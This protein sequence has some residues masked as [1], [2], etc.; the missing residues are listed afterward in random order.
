MKNIIEIEGIKLDKI[1]KHPKL[2]ILGAVGYRSCL[3]F[4]TSLN[5]L[6][7][8]IDSNKQ[9]RFYSSIFIDIPYELQLENKRS[10]HLDANKR[11]KNKKNKFFCLGGESGVIKILNIESCEFESYLK[12]HT[13]KIYDMKSYKHFLITCSGDSSIRFWNL[14]NYTCVGV[15]G[16]FG[17]HKDQVLSID[18]NED[19]NLL[20]STGTDLTIRQWKIDFKKLGLEKKFIVNES[21][22]T[23]DSINNGSIVKVGYYGD[24]I[25]SLSNKTIT[26]VYNN[27][28]LKS[29]SEELMNE[30]EFIINCNLRNDD[31]L[32]NDNELINN[33]E[34]MNSNELMNDNETINNVEL[35]NSNE[36]INN[37]QLMGLQ[38]EKKNILLKLVENNDQI[39]NLT[40][41]L[42]INDAIFIGL[43]KFNDFCIN[44]RIIKKHLLIGMS[45]NG[46]IYLY[47]LKLLTKECNLYI[48]ES[49][50]KNVE[51]FEIVDDYM[52]ITTGNKIYKLFIDLTIIK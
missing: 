32:I 28:N 18:I 2:N 51:D 44:F 13:G 24:L 40:F 23:F 52:F 22:T 29:F 9:E 34:L 50:V 7:R 5:I 33:D 20:V 12:G 6:Q 16:G 21:F 1:I 48:I 25:L 27:F 42:N 31:E 3:I 49:N 14:A 19:D 26:S 37:E 17:G 11:W 47:N 38:F 4:D 46:K 41:N 15:I 43:I 36:L 30:N 10:E 45:K 35:M 39:R 8:H